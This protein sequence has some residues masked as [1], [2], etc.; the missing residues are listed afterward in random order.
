M[1]IVALNLIQRRNPKEIA[2]TLTIAGGDDGCVYPAEIVT[3][4]ITVHLGTQRMADARNC[5]KGVSAGPQ[6]GN[7]TQVLERMPFFADRIGFR[8]IDDAVNDDLARLYFT[9]LS[10]ALRGNQGSRYRH[11]TACANFD[12]FCVVG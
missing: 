1:T 11:R 4:K 10:L 7:A 8:I 9:V 5:A 3:V 2:G 6:V 12:D